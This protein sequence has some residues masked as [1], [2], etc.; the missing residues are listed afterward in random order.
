[1]FTYV[2]AAPYTSDFTEK[3]RDVLEKHIKSVDFSK[4]AAEITT[5]FNTDNEYT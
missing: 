5:A 1:M 3:I 4:S 2:G